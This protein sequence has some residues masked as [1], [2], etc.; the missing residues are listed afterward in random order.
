MTEKIQKRMNF[1]ISVV[2]VLFIIGIAY[3]SFR[4]IGL[5]FPFIVALLLVRL[6]HP[7]I[8]FI[9]RKLKINK[10]FLSIVF[11]ALLYILAGG[12]I[13]FIVTQLVFLLKDVFT[14][15]PAY[16]RET[17]APALTKLYDWMSGLINKVPESWASAAQTVQSSIMDGLQNFI[18]SVS[19]KGVS[20]LTNFINGI[21]GFLI[22]L[23]FVILFSFFVSVH[24]EKIVVFIKAQLPEKTTVYLKDLKKLMKDTVVKYIR[25]YL[26]L[27]SI[28]FIE[29]SIGL[30]IIRTPGSIGVAA[31]IALFDALPIFGTG[32]IMIPWI[33]FELIQMNFSYAL[34]LAIVYGIVT[35]VRNIIEP[36]IVGDQLGLN[37][38]VSLMAIYVGYRLFGVLGMIFF[39]MLA[40]ILIALHKNGSIKLYREEIKKDTE[41]EAGPD[42]APGE[43]P[44]T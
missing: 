11:M 43:P 17:I 23:I 19:Q 25:A 27:M 35:V 3:A 42:T 33:I 10:K 1:I 36:K 12:L 31:G 40:Q 18:L 9:H 6:L 24:Y 2:Y 29:L 13:F 7:M 41:T 16:Y 39:P 30:T 15:L 37:P 22:S 20:F 8:M 4:L 32:G 34:A 44:A 28:T 5:I 38:V 14:T 21:P 26:I